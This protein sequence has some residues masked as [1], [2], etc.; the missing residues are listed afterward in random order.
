MEDD[1]LNLLRRTEAIDVFDI[2]REPKFLVRT[3][4]L[5]REGLHDLRRNGSLRVQHHHLFGEDELGSIT[6]KVNLQQV[7]AG[8]DRLGIRLRDRSLVMGISGK[9][10][11]RIT[12]SADPV[13]RKPF[14]IIEWVQVHGLPVIIAQNKGIIISFNIPFD[15]VKFKAAGAR[16][17]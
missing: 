17:C 6:V 16:H 10:N 14:D 5:G 7:I 4:Q 2:G 11:G 1:H 3:E 8:T 12:V 15:V 9:R 13:L